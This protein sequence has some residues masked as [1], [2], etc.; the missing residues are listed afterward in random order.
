MKGF[1]QSRKLSKNNVSKRIETFN[2]KIE[3][4]S[5]LSLKELKE[6]YPGL[7]GSYKMACEVVTEQKLNRELEILTEA[8]S[9]ELT[10]EFKQI[11]EELDG[12]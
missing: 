3:E 6:L 8:N 5:K 4:Y 12:E 10:Q 11:K 2:N 1:R 7:R 9:K